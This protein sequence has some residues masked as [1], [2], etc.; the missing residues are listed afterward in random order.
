MQIKGSKYTIFGIHQIPSNLHFVSSLAK[1]N[2]SMKHKSAIVGETIA[3]SICNEPFKPLGIL[4]GRVKSREG[5]TTMIPTNTLKH[6][7]LTNKDFHTNTWFIHHEHFNKVNIT[8]TSSG[9]QNS[10]NS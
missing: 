10:F 4:R 9:H 6:Y 2:Q 5:L 3:F 1:Q 8:I 7:V